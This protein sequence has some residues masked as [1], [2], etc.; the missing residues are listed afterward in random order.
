ME[1]RNT[2]RLPFVPAYPQLGRTT[3]RGCQYLQGRPIHETEMGR[4]PLNPVKT[5]S[6]PAVIAEESAVP[7]RT[8][9]L[10][11]KPGEGAEGRE[12]LVFDGETTEDLRGIARRLAQGGLLRESAGCAG[13]AE[14]LLGALPFSPVRRREVP[15]P[16][17]GPIL[18]ISGSLHPVSREQ[19]RAAL[20][21]GFPGIS[22]KG[23]D[24]A[25]PGW[26]A[27]TGA[28]SL[29]RRAAET[30]RREGIALLGTPPA[31]GLQTGEEVPAAGH[32]DVA[33]GLGLLIRT[34]REQAGPLRLVIF[35][36]D[37]LLAA[38]EALGFISLRPLEEIRPG[39]VLA[40]A[41]GPAGNTPI[42]TK[43]GAF[44][45]KDLIPVIR[46]YLQGACGVPR[47]GVV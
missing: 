29:A 17:G 42:V 6:I 43:S 44:G 46:D 31:L 35:G 13:F 7:V 18:V 33:R 36:G 8:V 16:E 23:E 5:S 10:G 28:A 45:E 2:R 34:I 12:I 41:E 25:R 37:T 40:R 32:E 21:A 3:R 20:D 47:V 26:I 4:D 27:G 11:E 30:L 39:V 1:V 19:V 22:V 38:A 14:A 15:A 24:L 9:P